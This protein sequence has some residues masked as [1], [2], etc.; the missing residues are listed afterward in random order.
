MKMR[1]YFMS[2]LTAAMAFAMVSCSDDEPEMPKIIPAEVPA[3][4]DI[5][6]SEASVKA[7][8]GAE[9]AA[10][11]IT[12]GAGEYHAISLNP[13][14]ATVEISGDKILVRGVVNG[15][16]E[17]LITDKA[18]KTLTVPVQ[19]YTSD[20]LKLDV[21]DIKAEFLIGKKTNYTVNVVVGNG[22]YTIKSD[23]ENVSVSITAEG[24]ATLSVKAA[25]GTYTA[26][27]TIGDAMG[28]TAT[29]T[30]NITG[31]DNPFDEAYIEYIKSLSP[32]VVT[33]D[34]GQCYYAERYGSMVNA[35]TETGYQF[36]RNYYD[37]YGYWVKFDGDCS[38]GKK[39][40]ATVTLSDY[41]GPDADTWFDGTYNAELEV[42]KTDGSAVWLIFKFKDSEGAIHYG[43]LVDNIPE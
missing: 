43:Y 42:I 21:T 20:E 19:S 14:I 33:V 29:V 13:E 32:R 28:L 1:Y 34:D 23:N 5:T 4:P 35:K 31:T 17:V 18:G 2:L 24:V 7:K 37:W 12:N 38:L 36:S 8:I 39:E 40:N 15:K 41:A 9:P 10:I 25:Q 30:L 22:D 16:T 11:N 27:V 6:V 3:T 26:K